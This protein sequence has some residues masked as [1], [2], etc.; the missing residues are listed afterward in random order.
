MKMEDKLKTAWGKLMVAGLARLD[1]LGFAREELVAMLTERMDSAGVE[2]LRTSE[3]VEVIE[4][5]LK[6]AEARKAP[7]N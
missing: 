1:E 3:V 5:A 7:T 6:L 2:A 4:A